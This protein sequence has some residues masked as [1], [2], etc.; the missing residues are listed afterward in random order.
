MPLLISKKKQSAWVMVAPPY[1]WPLPCESGD[2]R[3]LASC[4]P[5]SWMNFLDATVIQES[6]L[7][8]VS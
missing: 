7:I 3:T 6:I 8:Y 5:S 4:L 1:R 2:A